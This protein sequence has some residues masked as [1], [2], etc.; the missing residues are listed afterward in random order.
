VAQDT[1]IGPGALVGPFARLRQQSVLGEGVHVGNFVELKKTTM[2][3]QA[4]ANHLTY[5]GDSTIGG[6]TN[7]GAGTITC[8]YDGLHKHPTEIG[9]GVFVG[10]NSTLVAPLRIGHAAYIAAGSVITDD[11]EEEALAIGRERQVTKSGW[12][13]KRRAQLAEGDKQKKG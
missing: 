12:V 6:G 10:S 2:G 9:S 7:I 8:N 4:K 3:A 11:V 13:R 5:L 1:Q